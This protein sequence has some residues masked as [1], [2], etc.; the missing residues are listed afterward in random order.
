MLNR[1]GFIGSLIRALLAPQVV[2]PIATPEVLPIAPPL[3][4]LEPKIGSVLRIRLPN[5][6]MSDITRAAAQ[7]FKNSN[8]FLASVDKQYDNSFD[9]GRE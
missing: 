8:N 6:Y 1:R 5:D 3:I 2:K 9:D 7:N 4:P